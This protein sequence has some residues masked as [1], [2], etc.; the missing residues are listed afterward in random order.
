MNLTIKDLLDIDEIDNDYRVKKVF[1]VLKK[2]LG[3]STTLKEIY[4]MEPRSLIKILGF[5]K[6]SLLAL[7][8][9]FISHDI[10]YTEIHGINNVESIIDLMLKL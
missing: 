10:N 3:S 6:I 2:E 1:V 4:M 5:G 9:F 8:K 7:I